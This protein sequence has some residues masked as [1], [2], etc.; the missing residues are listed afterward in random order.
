MDTCAFCG[1]K[2]PDAV[3]KNMGESPICEH[4]SQDLISRPFP[5]WVKAFFAGVLILVAV[6]IAW[7]WKF[8]RAKAHLTTMNERIEE[9]DLSGAIAAVDDFHAIM[10]VEPDLLVARNF[11]MGIR[12]LANDSA[13]RALELLEDVEATRPGSFNTSDYL[14]SARIGA[15]FD[16][17]DYDGFLRHSR[18]SLSKRRDDPIAF[19]SVASAFACLFVTS[20]DEAYRDSTLE[21]LRKAK[22][23]ST[24][25][26][27][28]EYE[29]RILYRMHSKEIITRAAFYER[30]PNGWTP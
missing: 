16:K 18:E 15:A 13:E 4:C 25:T 14:I 5:S 11:W 20:G 17:G 21:M 7:N 24:D 26:S 19:G 23:I 9:G 6:S 30:F 22:A 28:N 29:Q 12:A 1:K 3:V 27:F 2:S 10:R 8:F